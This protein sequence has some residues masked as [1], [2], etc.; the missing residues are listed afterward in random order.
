MEQ[1]IEH[2]SD[3]GGSEFI[4]TMQ[5]DTAARTRFFS[6]ARFFLNDHD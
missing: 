4:S 1:R 5:V 3:R 6:F 2:V